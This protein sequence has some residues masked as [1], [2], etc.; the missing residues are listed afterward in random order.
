V[1]F[2][3]GIGDTADAWNAIAG[4][5]ESR[6]RTL[7]WDHRGHGRSDRPA[8]PASYAADLA[9]ADLVD[10]MANAGAGP[11]NPA[12]LVGH[13]LGGYLSLRTAIQHPHLTRALVLIS[14]GPGFRN[15]VAR[16]AWNQSALRMKIGDTAHPDARWLSV[17]RDATVIEN[18]PSIRVPTL[19][20]VGSEDRNFLA[21]K[22]YLIRSIPNATGLVIEGGRHSVHRSHPGPIG[23]AIVQLLER[24]D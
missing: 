19:V 21:A 11:D 6:A 23:Q 18:L 20:I 24:L 12:V 16:E 8:D 1:V 14:T 13:S 3:A 9:V 2:T 7:C 4:E 22:D 15:E 10:M 5:L 17:Q